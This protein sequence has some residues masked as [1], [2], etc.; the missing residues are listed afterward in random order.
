MSIKRI[1]QSDGGEC[2]VSMSYFLRSTAYC[3]DIRG[4]LCLSWCSAVITNNLEVIGGLFQNQQ[5]LVITSLIN[6]CAKG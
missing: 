4:S 3:E 1:L 5:L 6:L 2:T